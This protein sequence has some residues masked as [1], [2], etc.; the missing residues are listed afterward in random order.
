MYWAI[1]LYFLVAVYAFSN[2]QIFFNK[3]VRQEPNYA[4][5]IYG[6]KLSSLFTQLSPASPIM[7]FL[8]ISI[9]FALM[10][11]SHIEDFFKDEENKDETEVKKS[12]FHSLLHLQNKIFY[13]GHFFDMIKRVRTDTT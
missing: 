11:L 13:Q 10:R 7:V 5:P 12:W 9:I 3:I 2:Q 4:Y 1:V 8:F 6:H